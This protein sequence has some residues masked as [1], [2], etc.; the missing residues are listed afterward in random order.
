M[1][2]CFQPVLA[3]G[4]GF[5]ISYMHKAVESE[6]RRAEESIGFESGGENRMNAHVGRRRT[7][8]RWD[9]VWGP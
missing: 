4:L 8:E 1:M 5:N 3:R 7:G 2:G 6:E 9:S